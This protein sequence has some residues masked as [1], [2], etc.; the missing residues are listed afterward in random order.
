MG[1]SRRR[2]ILGKYL[3]FNEVKTQNQLNDKKLIIF[4]EDSDV[5]AQ[6]ISINLKNGL[7]SLVVTKKGYKRVEE[8][9]V[10]ISNACN[11]IGEHLNPCDIPIG[12]RPINKNGIF[13]TW[14]PRQYPTAKECE[15]ALVR[16]II[17]NCY[18][19]KGTN[20]NG[21]FILEVEPIV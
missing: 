9:V 15:T 18:R 5:F 12:I 10:A 17:E 4:S 16:V 2:K 20:A 19:F 14:M 6:T 11:D 7:R 3:S 1:E 8:I 21:D 13:Y